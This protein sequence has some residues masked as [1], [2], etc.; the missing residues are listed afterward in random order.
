MLYY[1]ILNSIILYSTIT[2]LYYTSPYYAILRYTI[3]YYTMLQYDILFVYYY[4][5]LLYGL[6]VVLFLF[7]GKPAFPIPQG[8][9]GPPLV[10]PA[11]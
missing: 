8:E 4:Y 3:L 6:S 11:Q 9:A 2:I 5:T 7:S 1:I 10:C